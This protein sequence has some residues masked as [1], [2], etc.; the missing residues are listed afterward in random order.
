MD[1]E[2][3][4]GCVFHFLTGNDQHIISA[5]IQVQ[6][7]DEYKLRFQSRKLLLTAKLE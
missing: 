6:I 2:L 4:P 7:Y 3:T 1:E 5:L